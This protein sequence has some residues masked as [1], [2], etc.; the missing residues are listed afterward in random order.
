MDGGGREGGVSCKS[1]YHTRG[2]ISDGDGLDLGVESHRN[3]VQ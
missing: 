1:I 2:V 3:G